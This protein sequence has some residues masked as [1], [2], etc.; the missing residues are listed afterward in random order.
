[1]VVVG[2]GCG[3]LSLYAGAGIAWAGSAG[4]CLSN[5]FVCGLDLI[6]MRCR[7]GLRVG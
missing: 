5:M 7:R 1:V 6:C 4:C 3:Y 2:A